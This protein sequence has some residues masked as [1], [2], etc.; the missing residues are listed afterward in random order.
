MKKI[1]LTIV[2]ALS[3]ATT[4]QADFLGA[5][6]GAVAW[7]PSLTGTIKGSS[8]IDANINLEDN[9]EY[10]KD[11][12]NSFMWVY[13]DHFIPLIPNAKIQKT[14]YTASSTSTDSITF[15]GKSYSNDVKSSL[16]LNQ[17]DMIAYYRI[18]DNWVNLDIGL[19]LKKIDGNIKLSDSTNTIATDKNF[20]VTIPM[21]YAKARF[22]MPFTGLS[23]ELDI[24]KIAYS[25]NSLID[26]KAGIVYQTSLGLGAITGIREQT[27]TLDDI[28]NTYGDIN[29]RGFYFGLFYHF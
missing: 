24:S 28:D 15:D 8:A 3:M 20:N 6:A 17:V 23:V 14:N 19:N 7:S 16:T 4:S 29:I 27:L 22:D 12:I 1:I 11:E 21:L 2:L 5:E 26:A 9:L 25:G 10:S 13:F 18:L